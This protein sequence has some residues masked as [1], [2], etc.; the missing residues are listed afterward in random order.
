MPLNLFVYLIANKMNGV[1]GELEEGLY[2][3]FERFTR[4]YLIAYSNLRGLT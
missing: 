3:Y 4:M 1:K 2:T